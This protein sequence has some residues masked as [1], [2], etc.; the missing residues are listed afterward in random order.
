MGRFTL[1]ILFC[2]E[3]KAIDLRSGAVELVPVSLKWSAHV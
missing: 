3:K 1:K 2:A